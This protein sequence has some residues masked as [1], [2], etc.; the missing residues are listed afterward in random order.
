MKHFFTA[1]ARRLLSP[2]ELT[3]WRL[4]LT[5]RKFASLHRRGL[6]QI[7][8]RALSRPQRLNLGSGSA[9]KAGFVNVDLASGG[10]LSLDLRRG[11]PFESN[12]CQF[13]FSEHCFEHIDYPEPISRLFRECLRVLAP[14]GTLTFSVPDTEWPLSD[15]RE[16]PSAAYF[17]VCNSQAWHPA[18]CTTRLEHINYHFRQG[19]EHRFAY[20]FE[21]AEKAL[22]A[23]GFVDVQRRDFDPSLDSEHRR[24]GSLFVS[25]RKRVLDQ[26][27]SVQSSPVEPR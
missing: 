1:V 4:V 7:R 23:A 12:C 8:K 18:D 11:L 24:L 14:G 2:G 17:S 20:D 15:Y 16:G 3:A 26:R 22:K 25:A 9:C 10:D 19:T 6:R 5:E 13:I 21:T 27:A